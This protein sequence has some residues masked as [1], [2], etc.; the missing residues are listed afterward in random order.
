MGL[1]PK[2]F[3]AAVHPKFRTPYKNTMLVGLARGHRGQRDADRRHRKNGEHRHSAG[4]RH[5]LHRGDDSAQ[6][7]SGAAP[8]IPH[9]TGCPSFRFLGIVF[10][11]YMMYKLGWVN[12]ARLI[13]WLVIGLVVYFNYSRYHS[14]VSNPELRTTDSE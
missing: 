6:Y 5:R 9:A 1:L 8:S 13:I 2:K 14:R 10:N 12:W 4:L 7:Q 3:F 11:G